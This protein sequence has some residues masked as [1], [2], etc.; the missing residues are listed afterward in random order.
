M[1]TQF[2]PYLRPDGMGIDYS[3]PFF[4]NFDTEAALEK[5][6]EKQRPGGEKMIENAMKN[7]NIENLRYALENAKRI[8][9]N[10]ANPT[11]FKKGQEFLKNNGG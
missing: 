7:H 4:E 10:Q 8:K 1:H 5:V 11:L 3:K 9:L 6:F 2:V